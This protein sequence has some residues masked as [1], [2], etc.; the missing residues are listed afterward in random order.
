MQNGVVTLSGEQDY[1]FQRKNILDQIEHVAGV[2]NVIDQMTV[3][4]KV[5]ASDVEERIQD[6]LNR[7]AEIESDNVSERIG[8]VLLDAELDTPAILL[9]L[10]A[11]GDSGDR[12]GVEML[13]SETAQELFGRNLFQEFFVEPSREKALAALARGEVV[14]DVEV[15]LIRPGGDE[16]L[17]LF[18]ATVRDAGSGAVSGLEGTL[19]D[20]T[21]RR[22]M[23]SRLQQAEKLAS[24]GQLSAG[25][26]HE[27]NNP[28]GLI[29]GYTQLILKEAGRDTQ[30]FEDL[31]VIEKHTMNCKKIVE[32][33]LQ[34]SR[35]METTKKPSDVNDLLSGVL[36]VL[37]GNFAKD[38]VEIEE[39]LAP[40]L[41]EV[42][43]DSEK[44]EQVFMN[45]LINARQAIQ[46]G[47]A[48]RVGTHRTSGPR[49]VVIRVSDTGCGIAE[50][51]MPRIFDP[52][53]TT[54]PTGKGTGL[55][56]SVSYGIVQ[57]HGGEIEVE[58]APGRGAVFT[59]RLPLGA[60]SSQKPRRTESS[61]RE[62]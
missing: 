43:M 19:K 18:S 25:V 22:M 36:R 50:E 12:A 40:G 29:L 13:G 37:R 3:K 44:M 61:E 51:I 14:K 58:S 42:T 2:V 55:G 4:P 10:R 48:I 41:P 23:D 49:P 33:L 52:F 56:L 35:S 57:D 15:R 54:K 59:V 9:L 34:F 28:L 20:I 7:H 17:A 46:G 16:L 39:T 45:L 32:D 1:H 24:L 38:G 8:N 47:G 60:G 5:S 30:A 53:Y 21:L 6:A 31:K 26:A 62:G 11:L 27:I